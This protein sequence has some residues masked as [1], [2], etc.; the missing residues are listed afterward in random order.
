MTRPLVLSA[1]GLILSSGSAA[2]AQDAPSFPCLNPPT[3]DPTFPGDTLLSDQQ[4][5]NCFAWQ[6]FIAVTWPQ[7]GGDPGVYGDPGGGPT[8]FETFMTSAELMPPADYVAPPEAAEGV[9]QLARTAKLDGNFNPGSD[10][11]EATPATA[12]LADRDGNLVWYE[13][14]VNDAEADYIIGNQLFKAASQRAMVEDGGRIDLPMGV[15]NDSSGAAEF[16][17]AWLSVTDPDDPRWTRYLTAD[18]QFCSGIG[19]DQVCTTGTVALVGLHILHK[20]SAQPSWTWSTF[21]HVDNAPDQA[22]VDA[23][24][25]DRE[26]RFYRESGCVEMPVPESCAA[27]DNATTT[28]CL[29]NV[30]PAYA[31]KDFQGGVVDPGSACQPYPIQVT[32]QFSL[33]STNENPIVATNAAAQAMIAAANPDSVFQYYQLVN[34]LWADSPV[35]ENAGATAPMSPLSE[36][37]FRPALNAFKVSNPMLE[38]YAQDVSCVECHSGATIKDGGGSDGVPAY[39]SDYSFIFGMAQQ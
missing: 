32:R 22:Q 29:P 36:T 20:T 12:W 34:V 6:E 7:A 17:A 26:Y 18:A 19:G 28:S 2:L 9:R 8:V 15:F 31:L 21:D 3:L 30:S 23:G 33:P 13:I 25:L 27:F 14:L 1:L 24:T 5:F 10:I 38:T 16:K 37:A 11:N 39:A 4:S 35:D